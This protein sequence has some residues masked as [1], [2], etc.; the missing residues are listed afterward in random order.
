MQIDPQLAPGVT[1]S[2]AAPDA[3][4]VMLSAFV[5]ARKRVPAASWSSLSYP[6][7]PFAVISYRRNWLYVGCGR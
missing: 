6:L 5:A 7:S 3:V 1:L 2:R 4:Y